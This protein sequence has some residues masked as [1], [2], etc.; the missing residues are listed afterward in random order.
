MLEVGDTMSDND[1]LGVNDAA[2]VAKCAA[3][4]IRDNERRGLLKAMKTEG[5]VRIF[6]R[7]EVE[8][9]AAARQARRAAPP[10]GDMGD[11][12]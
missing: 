4:T 5:G 7:S 12:A 11:A 8:R 6:L 9:F 1:L 10:T 3:D 2:R